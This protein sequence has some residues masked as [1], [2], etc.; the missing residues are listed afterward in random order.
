M[1]DAFETSKC[2]YPLKQSLE[3][4]RNKWD[5]G[6]HH[7]RPKIASPYHVQEIETKLCVW[8][9]HIYCGDYIVAE[10][11]DPDPFRRSVGISSRVG[12]P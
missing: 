8:S 10:W 11:L 2:S 3:L 5:S 4:S 12:V 9:S 7:I 1:P 6:R